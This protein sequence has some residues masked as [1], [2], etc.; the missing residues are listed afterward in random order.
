M[1]QTQAISVKSVGAPGL[2]D[3][4]QLRSVVNLILGSTLAMPDRCIILMALA[5]RA[6]CTRRM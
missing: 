2:T 5:F 1:A 6:N 4:L 3:L